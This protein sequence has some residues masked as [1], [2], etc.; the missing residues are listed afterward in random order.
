MT[1]KGDRMAI[2]EMEDLTGKAEGVVFPKIFARV[3]PYIL[4]DARLMIWGKIDRSRDDRTQ[5]IV[6]DAEPIEEVQMVMVELNPQIA[7][8]IAQQHRLRNILRSHQ[9]ESGHGKIPVV[10]MISANHQR[11]CV[12]LGAQFRVQD[13]QA[14]VR[15]LNEHGFTARS[16]A[17]CTTA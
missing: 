17:L 15:A 11:Q 10:A 5:I 7:G 13:Y 8:D 4:P 14:A 1:K 2:V 9:D 3:G 6:D 16:S 12:R